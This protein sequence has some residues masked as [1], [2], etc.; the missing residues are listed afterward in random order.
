MATVGAELSTLASLHRTF[1]QKAQEALDIKSTVESGVNSAVWTGTYSEQ[2]RTAWQEYKQNL[3]KL[4]LALL[5]AARDVQS[6]HNNIAAA[7]GEGDR[8]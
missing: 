3:D 8:I 4:N 2:F 7:T 6:N 1:N 5:D